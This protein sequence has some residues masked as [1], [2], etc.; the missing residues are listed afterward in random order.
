MGVTA[1][2]DGTELKNYKSG[3]FTPGTGTLAKNKCNSPVSYAG[4]IVGY[5]KEGT[6]LFWKIRVSNGPTYG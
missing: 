3:I 2:F 1:L 6:K 5:G 4:L